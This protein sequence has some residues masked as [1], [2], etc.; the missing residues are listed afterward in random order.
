MAN[1]L[2]PDIR[3]FRTFSFMA[4]AFSRTPTCKLGEMRQFLV[5]HTRRYLNK[6]RKF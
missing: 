6:L 3:S 4:C 2:P 5:P 1:R